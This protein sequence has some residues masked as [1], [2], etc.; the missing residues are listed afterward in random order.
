MLKYFRFRIEIDIRAK[1]PGTSH[2]WDNCY[3]LQQNNPLHG[4]SGP[5]SGRPWP[6][7]VHEA[8]AAAP[9]APRRWG[10]AVAVTLRQS[11]L[12]PRAA[13][14]LPYAAHSS[15]LPCTELF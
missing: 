6:H 7:F 5:A 1:P 3:K 15:R 9:P 2:F 8:R 4:S 12:R 14:W 10:G 13:L 11:N